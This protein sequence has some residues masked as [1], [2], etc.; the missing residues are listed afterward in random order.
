MQ[1]TKKENRMVEIEATAYTLLAEQGY[2]GA[3]MLKVARAAKA[4]N[5][6]MYRWYGD[7]RGLFATMVRRNTAD[8]RDAI[9]KWRV[10]QAAPE[11]SLRAV[12]P[13]LLHMVLSDRAILLNRAAAADASGELGQVIADEGRNKIAPLIGQ[14]I[15][16]TTPGA[17]ELSQT[18]SLF[19]SLLIGDQQIRRVIGAIPAPDTAA[20]N[21][22]AQRA[23][24][25]FLALQAAGL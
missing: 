11:E 18:T 6:T 13:V 7:K 10:A 24:T 12:A 9:D 21:Q 20:A 15:A 16:R 5:E 19:L 23:V 1:D 3:S 22:H 25:R 4:S 2:G 17:S 14:I 8:V